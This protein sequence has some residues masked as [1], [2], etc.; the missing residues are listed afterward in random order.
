MSEQDIPLG[1]PMPDDPTDP[2][3]D[4][5]LDDMTDAEIEAA[6]DN[7]PD[8]P[9][10]DVAEDDDYEEPVREAPPAEARQE[11]APQAQDAPKVESAPAQ[12]QDPLALERERMR[13]EFEL[14]KA[15]LQAH[16]SRLAARLG[17]LEKKSA[18]PSAPDPYEADAS[19][20]DRF[21]RLEKRVEEQEQERQA[22]AR[23]RA[24]QEGVGEVRGRPDFAAFFSDPSNLTYIQKAGEKFAS[25]WQE[26]LDAPDATTARLLA[27]AVTASVVA[28]ARAL[29]QEAFRSSAKSRSAEQISKLRG[30]KRAQAPAASVPSAVARPKAKTLDEMS[31]DE[32]ERLADAA[33]AG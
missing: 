6:L 2:R 8:A 16:N 10:P 4:P 7:P 21:S 19:E 31:D 29:Q 28:E 20:V 30:E 32:I 23:G 5:S 13:A 25:D 18:Q 17:N 9:Q 33:A 22:E 3:H 11:V 26:A 27:K 1:Q 24:I 15:K 12:E 14:E